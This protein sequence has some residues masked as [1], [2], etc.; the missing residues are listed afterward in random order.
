MNNQIIK[1][2]R[3]KLE[4][5]CR[6]LVDQSVINEIFK[7]REY[8]SAESV[9]K[10]AVSPIIDVGAHAG[11]F[12]LYAR[13][14]NPLVKIYALEPEPKNLENLKINLTNNQVGDVKIINGALG[15]ESGE[16]QLFISPDSHNHSL[17][18]Q[19][20]FKSLKTKV[21]S[22]SDFCRAEKIK[23]VALL[24]LDIEGGE[25]EILENLTAKDYA[26]VGAVILEYHLLPGKSEKSLIDRLKQN[27]FGVQKFPSRFDRKLGIVWGARKH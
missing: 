18:P 23:R 20:G 14:L 25:Y 24:K 1:F 17:I 5:V 22:L 6:D 3:Q 12:S 15:A 26:A 16:R 9:I 10:S 2:N 21:W 13:A 8:R 11:F 7:Y 4:V 27:G 19:K